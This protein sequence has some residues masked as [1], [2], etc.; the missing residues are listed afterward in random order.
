MKR[1][2]AKTT[3]EK[4]ELFIDFLTGNHYFCPLRLLTP[5][6]RPVIAIHAE[7]DNGIVFQLNNVCSEQR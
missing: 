7:C 1:E 2:G 3:K 4:C 6:K 5:R